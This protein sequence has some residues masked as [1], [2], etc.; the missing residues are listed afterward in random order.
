MNQR[1]IKHILWGVFVSLLFMQTVSAQQGGNRRRP[2]RN[3]EMGDM[4]FSPEQEAEILEYIKQAYPFKYEDVKRMKKSLPNVYRKTLAKA[5]REMKFA[6]RVQDE[7]PARYE[8]LK[9]ERQLEIR[10]H[11]LADQY[12]V[13]S[14]DE[15]K[16]AIQEELENVLDEAFQI[17]QLN[18]E[19]EIKN[20]QK[21]IEQLKNDN[22][23]RM[24]QKDKIIEKRLNELL[25]ISNLKW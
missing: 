10:S 25:G 15:E 22:E 4:D 18:R 23:A 7:D 14:T 16:A 24:R 13:A 20:L 9:K 6:L 5:W 8:N 11:E 3:A 17:R 1:I 12:K 19:G 21:K 2:V